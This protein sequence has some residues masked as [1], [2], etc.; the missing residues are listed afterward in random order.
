MVRPVINSEKRI[1]QITLSNVGV[2]TV[3]NDVIVNAQ[4]DPVP[5]APNAVTIGSVIKACYVE[6][7][8]LGDGQQPPTV[9]TTI[10]KLTSGG[11]SPTAADMT[12]L[13]AYNSKKGILEMHQGLVG[14]ANTNPTPFYRG[15][16]KIPKGKQRFGLGDSLN[17]SIK[18]IT[19]GVQYC[20]VFIF[21]VYN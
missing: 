4:Q 18:S 12:N 10:T 15:W 3:S 1:V 7:W 6:I 20:G 21:K 5:S 17:L 16:I 13:N 2:G 9:T 11:A 19:E 14:D 8:L